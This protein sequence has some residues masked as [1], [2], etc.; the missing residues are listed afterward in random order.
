MTSVIIPVLLC[1]LLGPGVGQLYNKEYKKGSLLIVLSALMLT[2]AGV[3]YYRAILPFLPA[4]IAMADPEAMAV[5]LKNAMREVSAKRF[6][7][8]FLFQG[9]IDPR[10]ALCGRGCLSGG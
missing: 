7:D 6:G 9:G 10:M 8:A 5:L 4:D 2:W 1:L 3:W